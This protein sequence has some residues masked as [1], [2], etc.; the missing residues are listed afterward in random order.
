MSGDHEQIVVRRRKLAA[1]RASGA[2]PFPNDFRPDHSAGEVHARFGALDA[3]ALESAPEWPSPDG[4]WP[5]GTSARPASSSCR[6]AAIASRSTPAAMRSATRRFETYRGLDLGDVIAVVGRPFRTRTGEL[7]LA[8][9]ALRLLVKTV[10]PLP[11]KWH[12]LQDVEARYRQRYV[13]LIVNPE[14]RRIFVARSRVL[15]GSAAF[16]AIAATSRWKPRSCRR[17]RAG[18]GE[19][20]RHPPQRARRGSLPP[21]RAGA[22]SETARRGRPR[23]VFEIA[24]CSGTRALHRHN[25]SSRCSSSTRRTRP[26]R[27]WSSSPRPCSWRSS[28]TSRGARGAVRRPHRRL[29]A[30]WP[31]RS[32]ADLVAEKTGVAA[33]RLL[34]PDVIRQLAERTGGIERRA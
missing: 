6:I 26:G 4:S 2:N 30:P 23:R 22:L 25:P 8:A 27:I 19:A 16:S 24:A 5:S 14:A 28:A 29:H 12:G 20:L 13:D 32:M 9:S 10:R 7:T 15:A 34:D 11:E 33:A 18:G 31:R 1:L 17:S 21:G 3:P